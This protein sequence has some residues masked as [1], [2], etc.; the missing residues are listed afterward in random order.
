MKWRLYALLLIFSPILIVLALLLLIG[1][2]FLGL[3]LLVLFLFA[4]LWGIG[5]YIAYPI[6]CF[7]LIVNNKV[8]DERL[9]NSMVFYIIFSAIAFGAYNVYCSLKYPVSELYNSLQVNIL[10]YLF[11]FGFSFVLTTYFII[12]SFDLLRNLNVK[13]SRKFKTSVEYSI[14]VIECLLVC[15][16]MIYSEIIQFWSVE[17]AIIGTLTVLIPIAIIT[18]IILSRY[19][20]IRFVRKSR[21]VLKLK[22]KKGVNL[23]KV[24]TKSD[25]YKTLLDVKSKPQ[26]IHIEACT[27]EE[28][29]LLEVFDIE[30]A[31][32]IIKERDEGNI[33]YD[34]DSFV[35]RFSIQ[36][37]EMVEIMDIIVFPPK[38][39]NKSGRRIDI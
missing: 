8:N 7:G 14:Y 34:I 1:A 5:A 23:T 22:A 39:S 18:T 21:K 32:L 17:T 13:I 15:F 30:K 29:M 25:V 19:T 6:C 20:Y 33:W 27:K 24:E 11:I 28:L 4:I 26:K 35:R 9:T 10:W 16:T 12:L 2:I 37:H 36:P 3:L 31:T 38:P